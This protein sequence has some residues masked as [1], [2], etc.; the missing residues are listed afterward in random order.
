[1]ELSNKKT[2]YLPTV[3]RDCK[4]RHTNVAKKHMTWYPIAVLVNA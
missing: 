3:L 4:K 1:M 2:N